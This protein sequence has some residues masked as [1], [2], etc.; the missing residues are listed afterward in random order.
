MRKH[1]LLSFSIFL[2]LS[3]LAVVAVAEET[4]GD[5][6]AKFLR[7]AQSRREKVNA[8]EYDL[9]AVKADASLQEGPMVTKASDQG[10]GRRL[11]WS[12]AGYLYGGTNSDNP[13]AGRENKALLLAFFSADCPLSAKF[14]PELARLEKD[15]ATSQVQMILVDPDEGRIGRGDP[16]FPGQRMV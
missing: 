2:G 6:F 1:I 9:S 15:C 16:R 11:P 7:Q 8:N 10:V 3:M 4:L 13:V 12:V 14:A 5:K